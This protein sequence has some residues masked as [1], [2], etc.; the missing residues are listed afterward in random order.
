MIQVRPGP[1]VSKSAVKKYPD[2]EA[3]DLRVQLDHLYKEL[4]RKDVRNEKLTKEMVQ[5]RTAMSNQ[6]VIYIKYNPFLY[7]I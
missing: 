7:Y 3:R 2:S 1:L 6:E 5:M 4:E